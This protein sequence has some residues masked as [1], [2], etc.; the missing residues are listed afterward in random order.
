MT[1]P[2]APTDTP[3]PAPGVSCCGPVGEAAAGTSYLMDRLAVLEYRVRRLVT[4]R[5]RSE[6]APDPLRGLYLSGEDVGHLL[7]RPG[8][9]TLAPDEREAAL[10]AA[11]EE[12][13]DAAERAGERPRLR[14]LAR[15]YA[16]TE[17]QTALLLAAL[18]PDL[19]PRFEQLYG[20][21]N[22][23]I[24]LRRATTGLAL[25]L[26]GQPMVD[27]AARALTAP[28]GTLCAAGLVEVEEAE[29]P[30]LTRT[31][32]VADRVTAHL[33][34]DDA[35]DPLLAGA[36]RLHTCPPS[37]PV[38][39]EPL[40]QRLERG[41]ERG[42]WAYLQGP[43]HSAAPDLA[44]A[45]AA[46][47]RPVLH[48]DLAAPAL[49][50]GPAPERVLAAAVREAALRGALLAAG[51]LD[52]LP[53]DNADRPRLL[54][55][56]ARTALPEQAAV[57]TGTAA[58]DARW[59]PALPL[60][61]TV[62]PLTAGQRTAAWHDALAGLPALL[63]HAPQALAPYRLAPHQIRAAASTARRHTDNSPTLE[64]LSAA[65]RAASGSSLTRL[66]RHTRPTA[67]WH[68]LVLPDRPAQQLRDL[69]DRYRHRDTVLTQW[70]LRPTSRGS[71]ITALFTGPSGTGKTLAAE[72]LATDLGLDLYT[73]NLATV[74]DKYIGE[75]EKNLD[76]IFTEA[77]GVQGLLLF[78]E[79]DAL[80]GKR[81]EVTH[82]HD[83]YANIETAYLL[84]RLE[85]FDGLA[86]LTTNL[87]AHLDDAFLRRLDT[88]IHFPPPG[89]DHRRL[90]WQR[91]LT[92]AP[93]DP[94]LPFDQLA[95]FDL[96]GGNI[97]SCATTAA[98]HAAARNRP[99]T[100]PDLH[101]ALRDEY[102]KLGRL[103]PEQHPLTGHRPTGS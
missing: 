76:R 85:T 70:R 79:A 52:A 29:R 25:Q 59:L 37:P 5:L 12:R 44:L 73:I 49:Q 86:L 78:D 39:G 54:T 17:A 66:A 24:T 32:R 6:G 67:T 40:L 55:A 74:V 64:D 87:G 27:P 92:A 75:T 2:A 19:D 77:T 93:H 84:Q 4:D 7:E 46:P 102:A 14:D 71:G 43:S 63:P 22:D 98:Y 89:P 65:V 9:A 50:A 34:G 21:L 72:I 15:R 94:H 101:T 47:H 36:A 80:F 3:A 83:R 100:T 11:A 20:Y 97:R 30:F 10:R 48:L 53:A 13:A 57:L 33:L 38:P 90:L 60:L 35:C 61:L 96:T 88:T 99:I 42:G 26:A 41:L 8:A 51:P 16:L 45:L 91:C 103:M 56:L 1:R 81:S 23:D 82:A 31:L 62:P 18:A 28:G 69:A 68:D 95:T 58:W